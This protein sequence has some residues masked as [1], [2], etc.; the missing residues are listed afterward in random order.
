MAC[1]F[2]A[3]SCTPSEKEPSQ[4]H[5]PSAPII[6]DLCGDLSGDTASGAVRF[7][8]S[9]DK[10][11]T[12][13]CK[14]TSP[15]GQVLLERQLPAEQTTTIDLDG[16]QPQ[17]TYTVYAAASI[18]QQSADTSVEITTAPAPEYL[19]MV[20]VAAKSYSFRVRSKSEHGFFFSSGEYA[21]LDYLHPGWSVDDQQSMKELLMELYPFEGKGDTVIE[22]IDGEQPSWAQIPVEVLADTDYFVMA[23]E[24]GADGKIAS[25]VAFVRFRTLAQ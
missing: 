14:V 21:A 18:A 20:D 15:Q 5:K 19:S 16:L 12:A 6:E 23:A 3:L 7:S 2:V 22:C 11:E 17:T 8:V 10:A 24:I 25:D 13:I 4:P 1:A 9:V